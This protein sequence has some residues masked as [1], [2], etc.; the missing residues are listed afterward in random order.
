MEVLLALLIGGIITGAV[1]V[2]ATVSVTFLMLVAGFIQFAHGEIVVLAMYV[3]WLAFSL[4]ADSLLLSIPAAIAAAV[5]LTMLLEPLT[6]R[7][8]QRRASIECLILTVAFGMILTEIMSH[9][10]N[11]GMPVRFPAILRGG[12][13]TMQFGLITVSLA[14]VGVLMF[15][16]LSLL[17]F[18]YFLYHTKR[19]MAMR[20]V[21]INIDTARALGLPVAKATLLSFVLTGFLAGVTAILFAMALGFASAPLGGVVSFKVLAVM[22]FAGLGN[23][24]GAIFCGL[25]LGIIESLTTGYF[26]GAWTDAIS[27]GI[28]MGTIML[29]PSGLFGAKV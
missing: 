7:L 9:F 16:V 19:G 28:I 12:G 24:R 27:M 13:V 3:A 14:N 2:M 5:L 11:H 20:A 8:R 6:R 18:S 1:Y 10:F 23:L 26:I 29:R 15:S 21:A 4:S 22:L 25:L 17:A